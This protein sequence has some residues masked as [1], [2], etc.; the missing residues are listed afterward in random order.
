MLPSR[1]G[2]RTVDLPM[3]LMDGRLS[4]HLTLIGPHL[5]WKL[6]RFPEQRLTRQEA[7]RGNLPS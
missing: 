4:L 1:A 2:L 3:G 7:L 6:H 5:I